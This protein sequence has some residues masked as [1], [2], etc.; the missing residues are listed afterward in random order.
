MR[1]LLPALVLSALP[2]LVAASP[3]LQTVASA[4][5][6]DAA[7]VELD[8]CLGDDKA[9]AQVEVVGKP[10]DVQLLA[11]SVTIKARKP[12]G[13][14]PRARVGMPV[15]ISVNGQLMR[16]ATVWFAVSVHHDV[17]GYAAD[18]A[19]GTVASALKFTPHDADVATL[20][21]PVVTDS[22]QVQ[23]MRLRHAVLAGSPV[24]LE[25]F[26][27]IPDVDRQQRVDV[28][29][30]YGVIKLQTK[31]TAIGRG[32]TGDTVLVLVDGAEEPVHARIT[33]KG[34]VQVVD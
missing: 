22:Q 2:L 9:L 7:R 27:H 33:D 17:P 1:R 31:G 12:E 16:S 11:G 15:D 34:V 14:W 23:G 19:M 18:A 28:S 6:V 20:Q 24:L 8:S 25:D 21:G 29:A 10:E 5:I 4:R 26:E 3:S 32:N 13:R 30:S